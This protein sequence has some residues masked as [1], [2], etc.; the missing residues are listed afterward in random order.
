MKRHIENVCQTNILSLSASGVEKCS[1]DYQAN[2]EQ[3]LVE[4]SNIVNNSSPIIPIDVIQNQSGRFAPILPLNGRVS[5]FQV[6]SVPRKEVIRPE[7]LNGLTVNQYKNANPPKT[8]LNSDV[9]E[10]HLCSYFR[11]GVGQWTPPESFVPSL[12]STEP[13]GYL[14]ADYSAYQN[15][16]EEPNQ[17]CGASVMKISFLI[18]N[19][20]VF[21]PPVQQN[22]SY[23]P[24]P[25]TI[26]DSLNYEFGIPIGKPVMNRTVGPY[27]G[28]SYQPQSYWNF[29]QMTG[30]CCQQTFVPSRM[31]VGNDQNGIGYKT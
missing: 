19:G 2:E 1:K 23:F 29:G 18:P 8:Q 10:Y 7:T 16:F 17:F 5:T 31:F 11:N 24:A 14:P 26:F 22:Q 28:Q 21:S 15:S 12:Q 3:N 27:F 13:C 9:P 25:V 20:C 6:N 30:N 4:N